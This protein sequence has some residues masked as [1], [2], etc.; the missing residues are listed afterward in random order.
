MKLI[1]A[2]TNRAMELSENQKIRLKAAMDAGK[3]SDEFGD[4]LNWDDCRDLH[5]DIALEQGGYENCQE[6]AGR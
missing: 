1:N 4:V 3:V 5:G 2:D 6:A